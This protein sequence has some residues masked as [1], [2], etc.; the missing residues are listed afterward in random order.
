MY[1]PISQ[2][3]GRA[4]CSRLWFHKYWH[5][6]ELGYRDIPYNLSADS[7]KD[8]IVILGDSYVAGHGI[9]KEEDR[10]SNLLQNKLGNAFRVFNLGKNGSSTFDEF[11]RL[12]K[13]P[14]KFDKLVLVHVPNDLE[15]LDVNENTN[16]NQLAGTTEETSGGI[17]DFFVR[18]SFFINF[19]SYTIA[20]DIFRFL[21]KAFSGERIEE[22]R[23]YPF[24]DSVK[25]RKHLSNLSQ[26]YEFL[27]ENNIKM[28]IIS[29]PYPGQD[30]S[31]LIKYYNGFIEQLKINKLPFLDANPICN[32]LALRQQVV[33][34]LDGHPSIKVHKMVADSLYKRLKDDG[35]F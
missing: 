8:K 33:N 25:L 15:Y 23:N 35:W 1:A 6:N 21:G 32:K 18:E 20:G 34:S 11:E 31:I 13:F 26:E 9:N 7:L 4:Y 17:R 30:D 3:D 24:S 5:Q 29:F 27:K 16:T 10:M 12:K 22:T 2:G 28:I 14:Y 19:L